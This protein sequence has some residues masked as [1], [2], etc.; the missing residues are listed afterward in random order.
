[1]YPSI[2]LECK[3]VWK[4]DPGIKHTPVHAK[5]KHGTANTFING[6]PSATFLNKI[7]YDTSWKR[8]FLKG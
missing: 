1:M 3:L 5:Q 6:H 2:V 7:K 8:H 4:F